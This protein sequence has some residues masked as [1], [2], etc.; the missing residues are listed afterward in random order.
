ML[1]AAAGTAAIL[2]LTLVPTPG[3]VEFTART[4]LLCIVCGDRGG[5]DVALNLLLFTPM[6]AGL[7]LWGWSWRRVVLASL[8]L[9]FAVELLQYTVVAGRDASLSDL[10]T[11]TSGAA[12]AAAITPHLGRLLAPD[13]V[14]ARRLFLAAIVLWGGVISFSALVTLP[15]VPPG[16]LRN[17]CTSS[18][19]KA[20][21]F[22]K[23]V[24]SVTLNGVRLPCDE[25]LPPRASLREAL[26]R[27]DVELEVAVYSGNLAHRRALVHTVRGS[28][29]YLLV[30]A[31]EGR[32]V[33]FSAPTAGLRLR[34]YS[35]ILRLPDAFPPRAG[36]LVHLK[37]GVRNHR[38]WVSSSYSGEIHRVELTIGPTHGW[39]TLLPWGIDLDR[40]LRVATALW[41]GGLILPAAYWAGFIRHPAWG[42]AGVLAALLVGLGV[43]PVLAGYGH[44]HPVEWLGGLLGAVVGWALR[45]FAPYLQ[46][47]CGS[48]STSAFSLR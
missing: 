30:L 26:R 22:L 15:W 24:R 9:S 28:T 11:N 33:A 17:D 18:A 13:P 14:L 29:N 1:L 45:R 19:G 6:A 38:M 36:V 27:G 40:W 37:A 2:G 43:L 5:A 34:L 41:V 46:S 44:A 32:S 23:T 31:Q 12:L 3:Q 35:P 16:T 39:S 21:T 4:P 42:L 48:P 10:L 47:R 8:L 20:D 25:D 7:R